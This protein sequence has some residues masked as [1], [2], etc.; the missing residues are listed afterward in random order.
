MGYLSDALYV[1]EVVAISKK[2]DKLKIKQ[3]GDLKEHRLAAGPWHWEKLG[4]KFMRQYEPKKRPSTYKE[5]ITR[6]E[7][8]K[9]FWSE[10]SKVIVCDRVIFE[11]F[12][13][14]LSNVV[15]TTDPIVIHKLPF[16]SPPARVFFRN[17][18]LR[19]DFNREL[20]KL[21]ASGHFDRLFQTHLRIQKAPKALVAQH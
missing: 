19:D 10:K 7:Q 17:E 9:S 16:K 13:E 4:P 20:E 12:Q 18:D 5:F 14:Y 15:D 11:F 8:H 1:T 3:F 2:K 21:R 6:D